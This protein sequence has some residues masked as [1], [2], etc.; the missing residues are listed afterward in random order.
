MKQIKIAKLLVS[1]VL[2]A[3]L[4]TFINYYVGDQTG[5]TAFVVAG[6]L[7]GAGFVKGLFKIHLPLPSGALFDALVISDTTN[8]G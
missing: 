2:I 8:A 6:L 7:F 1:I 5:N 3:V 4:S